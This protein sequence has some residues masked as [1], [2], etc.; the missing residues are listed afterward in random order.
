MELLKKISRFLQRISRKIH[1]WIG[2]FL[3]LFLILEAVSGIFLNHP[4]LI[5]GLSMPKLLVPNNYHIDN[6]SRSALI[7]AQF[8]EIDSNLSFVCGRKGVW[9]SRDAGRTLTKLDGGEYPESGYYGRAQS[10]LLVEDVPSPYLLAGLYGGLYKYSLSTKTWG[11]V[12]LGE[13]IERIVKVDR[14]QNGIIAFGRS[15]IYRSASINNLDFKHINLLRTVERD[16][17]T[18]IDYF[19]HIHD[20]R[21]WGLGGRLLFD[22]AGLI[23]IFLSVS[24]IYMWIL[25]KKMKRSKKKGLLIDKNKIRKSYGFH[26]KY[27]FK[28]GI[29]A[30]LLLLISGGTGL[31][32]R[33][34]TVVLLGNNTVDM[35]YYPGFRNENPWEDKIRNATVDSVNSSIYLDCTDGFW[36]GPSDFSKPFERVNSP[37]PIFAMG[38]TVFDSE[39]DGQLLIGSFSGLCRINFN[40][41]TR[42]WYGNSDPSNQPGQFRPSSNMITGYFKTPTGEEYDTGYFVGLKQASGEKIDRFKMPEALI[43]SDSMPLWNYMFEIHNGRFFKFLFG[44]FYILIIP[45][46]SLLFVIMSLTGIYDWIYRK[47]KNRKGK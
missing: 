45:I 8:S 27:H 42:T 46:G 15:N 39:S 30:A 32:M 38:A 37:V 26:S 2:L 41:G 7:Q 12:A 29:W 13:D 44:S 10:I 47:I 23:I 6:W 11:K 16:E 18:L 3:L 9:E 17:I 28:L 19:F 1:K 4:D 34:P 5:S 22:L 31:F 35:K 14:D 43:K 36:H 24:G 25:P 33:P 20:G 40:T 21:A